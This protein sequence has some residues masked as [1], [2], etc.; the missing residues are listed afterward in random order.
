MEKDQTVQLTDRLCDVVVECA[1]LH[2][3]VKEA[4][5]LCDTFTGAYASGDSAIESTAVIQRWLD[6]RAYHV[7]GE[8]DEFAFEEVCRSARIV[9]E[10]A[11]ALDETI[12]S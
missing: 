2:G 10:I 1:Q 6:E 7:L 11:V 4:L 9:L 12:P 3:D 8:N 5:E